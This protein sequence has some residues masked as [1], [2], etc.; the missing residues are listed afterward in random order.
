VLTSLIALLLAL[1]LF[2]LSAIVVYAPDVVGLA[3]NLNVT[4]TQIAFQATE[5]ALEDASQALEATGIALEATLQ[6]IAQGAFDNESTRAALINQA[7]VL[8]QN[9]TQAALDIAATRTSIAQANAQQATQSAID[10]QGTQ[11]ALDRAATQVEIEYQG[12]QAAIS[13]NAT[14]VALGFA[15]PSGPSLT[16]P[17]SLIFDETFGQ[18]VQAGGLWRFGGAADW[19]IGEDDQL[20]A[21]RAGSWLLTEQADFS[22]YVVE[23]RFDPVAGLAGQYYVL[24]SVTDQDGIA[25]QVIYDGQQATAVGLYRVTTTQIETGSGLLGAQIT[26]I[27]AVQI[28]IAAAETIDARAEVTPGRIVI[29]IN[30]QAVIDAAIEPPLSAGAVG[31]QFP[32][33]TTLRRIALG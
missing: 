4:Q 1:A 8:E 33:A 7:A 17:P 24:L 30:G 31:V 16:Q 20:T 5:N 13:Q 14:A 9:A 12:T 10:F 19:T 27:Q 11:T 3:P 21:T 6:G 29:F 28:D 15:T 32:A 23:T 25:L 2:T 18:A 22:A 26:P